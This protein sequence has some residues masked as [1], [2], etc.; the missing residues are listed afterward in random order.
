MDRREFESIAPEL[1]DNIVTT[2]RRI[3]GPADPDLP[4]DVAQDTLLRLW[5]LRDEL[6]SYRSIHALAMVMARN[7]AIDLLRSGHHDRHLSLDGYDS[8]DPAYDPHQALEYTEAGNRLSGILASLP[9]AQQALI[10]MRH[11]DGMEIDEIASVTGSSSGAIR[12][13]LSRAR[14]HIKELFLQQ[15]MN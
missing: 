12:T 15:N 3:V 9:S 13:M 2:V 14:N 11:I 7:R 10:K 1:R 8:P 4:D 5:T 6:D